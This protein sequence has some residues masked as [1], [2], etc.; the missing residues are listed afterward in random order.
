MGWI[1]SVA[2]ELDFGMWPSSHSLMC[3]RKSSYEPRLLPNPLSS[4]VAA[5]LV[6]VVAYYSGCSSI[7]SSDCSDYSDYLSD[8]GPDSDSESGTCSDMYYL[9]TVPTVVD[10]TDSHTVLALLSSILI[11]NP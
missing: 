10:S 7:H 5:C 2:A 3:Y 9:H 1:G 11:D 4:Q 8:P 6:E